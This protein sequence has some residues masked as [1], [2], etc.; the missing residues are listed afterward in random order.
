MVKDYPWSTP[1]LRKLDVPVDKDGNPWPLDGN[2]KPV[3]AK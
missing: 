3:V 1:Q 2:G